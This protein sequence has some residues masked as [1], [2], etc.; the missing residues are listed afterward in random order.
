MSEPKQT[1]SSKATR[2]KLELD[3]VR[4]TSH[5]SV[6]YREPSSWSRSIIHLYLHR[7][8]QIQY[9]ALKRAESIGALLGT[10][11]VTKSD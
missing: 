6:W 8:I 11:R 10:E 5:R 4:S 7:N 3:S 2:D 9:R 1:Q